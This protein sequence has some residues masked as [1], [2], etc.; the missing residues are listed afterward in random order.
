MAPRVSR[1][2]A[3]L[4]LETFSEVDLRLVGSDH[5]AEH[6]STEILCAGWAIEDEPVSVWTPGA[7]PPERLFRHVEEGGLVHAWNV[8]FEIPLMEKVAHERMGWPRIPFVRWRDTAIT[9]LTLGLPPALDNAGAAL[10]LEIQK[11]KWGR[12]LVLKLCKPR[13]PS[14]RVQDTR[15]TPK[16]NPTDFHDLYLYC[17]KDVEAE[18]AIHHALP[19]RTLTPRELYLWRL[20]TRMNR[21]GWRID[22]ESVE[23]MIALLDEHEIECL[24]ELEVVTGGR[25]RTPRQIQK[26]KVWLA[27][28]G[29]TLPDLTKDTVTEALSPAGYESREPLSPEARR[30]LELRQELGKSSVAKYQAMRSRVCADGTVKELVL[31]HGASTGRDA[32]R[33]IQIQNFP[34]VNVAKTEEGVTEAFADLDHAS[35]EEIAEKYDSVRTFA[36]KMLRHVLIAREGFDLVAADFSSIETRMSAWLCDCKHTSMSCSC[37]CPRRAGKRF[38]CRGAVLY[39]LKTA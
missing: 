11:A 34:R 2:I 1:P 37:G 39:R 30:F 19:M 33:G 5:Y 6:P 16:N 12:H 3:H 8:G 9:A 32:G 15:W 24:K 10:G 4:D 28:N 17:A 36:S 31:H 35:L 14:K 29:V 27:E 18:R 13:R 20:T 38:R 7:A 26:A 22:L 23:K 21:R 25:V